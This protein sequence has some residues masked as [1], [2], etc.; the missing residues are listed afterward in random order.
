MIGTAG[1]GLV[2]I[3]GRGDSVW[4]VGWLRG[5]LS[6]LLCVGPVFATALFAFVLVDVGLSLVC[7]GDF[8]VFVRSIG[9]VLCILVC[10]VLIGCLG[11]VLV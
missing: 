2:R 9:R 8:C 7:G 6:P 3:G 4:W 5:C 11:C 1:C 10:F